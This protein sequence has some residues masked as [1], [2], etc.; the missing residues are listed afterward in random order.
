MQEYFN[1]ISLINPKELQVLISSKKTQIVFVSG[2]KLSSNKLCSSINLIISLSSIPA[3]I[4]NVYI[5]ISFN[6]AIILINEVLPHPVSPII[7]TGIFVLSLNEI[8]I[9]LIKLSAVNIYDSTI[10][11]K[12]LNSFP[13]FVFGQESSYSC[14]GL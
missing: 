8:K 13:P 14:K 5:I 2:F 1:I 9:S 3:W 7:I 11:F 6:S 12:G 10:L 4:F